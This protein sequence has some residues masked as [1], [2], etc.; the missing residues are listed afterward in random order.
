MGMTSC[1]RETLDNVTLANVSTS[2][3]DQN[4]NE[5]L[6]ER[7]PTEDCRKTVNMYQERIVSFCNRTDG[8]KTSPDDFDRKGVL[9]W[10]FSFM[11]MMMMMMASC[12]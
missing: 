7:R 12:I 4:G 2:Q 9:V 8:C 3:T 6:M 10:I 1:V 11:T 5:A